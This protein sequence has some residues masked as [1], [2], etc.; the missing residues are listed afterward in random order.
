MASILPT[1]ES[2]KSNI[3]PLFRFLSNIPSVKRFSYAV[4]DATDRAL[5]EEI[6]ETFEKE[7]IP[8]LD[9]LGMRHCNF[10]VTFCSYKITSV[11]GRLHTWGL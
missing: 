3:V 11:R 1:L 7:V 8:V 2:R 10:T 5:V 6:F 4:K 9:S